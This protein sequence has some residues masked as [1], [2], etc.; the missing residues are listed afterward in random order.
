MGTSIKITQLT[1]TAYI[2]AYESIEPSYLIGLLGFAP[3]AKAALADLEARAQS[4][5]SEVES[6]T[7]RHND[8]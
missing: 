8:E 6:F 2:A 7:A 5:Q 3:T 1:D 4:V